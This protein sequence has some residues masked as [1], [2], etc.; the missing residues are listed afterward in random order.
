MLLKSDRQPFV[1][2]ELKNRE[3]QKKNRWIFREYIQARK[4]GKRAINA[5]PLILSPFIFFEE[6]IELEAVVITME[7]ICKK[8][9]FGN[10]VR[11]TIT[12]TL[13]ELAYDSELSIN[14]MRRALG[15]L[16]MVEANPAMFDVECR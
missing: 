5:A 9:I 8:H 16:E 10:T 1:A 14:E 15:F 11:D 4:S 3:F 7:E 2:N 6:P 13:R 12:Q